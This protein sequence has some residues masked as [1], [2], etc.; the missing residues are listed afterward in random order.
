MKKT[1]L[2]IVSGLLLSLPGTCVSAQTISPIP[3]VNTPLV[4]STKAPGGHNFVLTV[5]GNGFTSG[6]VVQWN[7]RAQKT[8]FVSTTQLTAG[9]PAANIATA[10][11]ATVT[12]ANAGKNHT[13]NP[14]LFQVTTSE[15]NI[16]LSV[17]P[18]GLVGPVMTADL[19][20][21]GM[22]D[23]I[24]QQS[25]TTL[26]I[27]LATGNGTFGQPQVITL[28]IYVAFT[29]GRFLSSGQPDIA[30]ATVNGVEILP[31]N[32]SGQ[33]G[34][35]RTIASNYFSA[36]AAADL[37]GDG[38]LDLIGSQ[39]T[40]PPYVGVI[41]RQ[42][43]GGFKAPV[44]Y[45]AGNGPTI[46]APGDFNRDGVADLA[47]LNQGD[48]SISVFLGNGDGTFQPQVLYSTGS[49]TSIDVPTGLLV[50]DFNGDGKLD[51][52]RAAAD[53]MAGTGVLLGNGDGTFQPIVAFQTS[54]YG[55][56]AGDFNGDGILDVATGVN[57][58]GTGILLGKGDGTFSALYNFDPPDLGFGVS[59]ADFNNNGR[60]DLAVKTSNGVMILEQ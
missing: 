58:T 60:L 21:D 35:P 25:S 38:R 10:S 57:G 9:I 54:S 32:G 26:Q 7:G 5:N 12:V 33:F 42:A 6:S 39:E 8:K 48:D 1:T 47:V 46:I 18:T 36:L 52:A 29:V 51:L 4:P 30:V 56:V 20:G 24:V 50:A 14:V 23:L 3:L 27:A 17:I 59:A 16:S 34:A 31:N 41:L 43:N 45:P 22:P 2:A 40:L 15:Q 11:T 19:N 44:L 49:G 55:L 37:D 13:S 53:F 28:P